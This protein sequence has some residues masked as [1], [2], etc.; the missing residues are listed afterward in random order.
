MVGLEE[1]SAKQFLTC[2]SAGG[3]GDSAL[4]FT[5]CPEQG[6]AHRLAHEYPG[7]FSPFQKVH[8]CWKCQCGLSGAHLAL[9]G[10][11]QCWPCVREQ[12]VQGWL[13][14]SLAWGREKGDWCEPTAGR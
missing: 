2:G 5:A 12:R 3:A 11:A 7:N 10:H 13:R 8:L 9:W 4:L 6:W 1:V 14:R